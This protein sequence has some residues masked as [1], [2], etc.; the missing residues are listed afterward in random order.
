MP[1]VRKS[2]V[3]IGEDNEILEGRY[4]AADD[5]TIAFEAFKIDTDATPF[6][7]G[8]PDDACQSPH[9]GVVLSGQVTYRYTDGTQEVLTAGAAYYI[10]P[11][12]VPIVTAGTEV[13]EFSPTQ[14]LRETLDV[15]MANLADMATA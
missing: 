6:F 12:H 7:R 13:V 4:Y 3:P 15:V 14:S 8:L 5:Y 11:G 1:A 10:R 2:E 9:W